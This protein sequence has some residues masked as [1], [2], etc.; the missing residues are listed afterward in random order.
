MSDDSTSSTPSSGDATS[1]PS[2]GSADSGSG[3]SAPAPDPTAPPASSPPPFQ[4]PPPVSGPPAGAA[5]PPPVSGPPAGSAYPPPGTAYPPHGGYQAQMPGYGPNPSGERTA[6]MIA[7]F[8]A[9]VAALVFGG[10]LGWVPPLIAKA[11]DGSPLVRAHSNESINF[12][13]TWAIANVVA[14][15]LFFCGTVVTI[16]FGAVV[17]WIVP[18]A[19]FLIAVIFPIIAGIKASNGQP[20]RYPMKVT[21][22]R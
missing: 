13:L 1:A 22:V 10:F 12:Q 15:V 16:G 4:A 14:W 21:F 17:L 6:I 19:T 20:Y 5:Y 2:F 18:L 8:G 11:T 7:H 9:A 3:P